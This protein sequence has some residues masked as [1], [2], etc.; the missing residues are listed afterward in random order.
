MSSLGFQTMYREIHRH[1]GAS[2]ERAFLPE[3]P[4]DYRKNR[5]PVLTYESEMPLSDFPVVAFSIAYELEL[6]GNF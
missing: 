4:E 3:N 5:V 6:A 2:A 1:P